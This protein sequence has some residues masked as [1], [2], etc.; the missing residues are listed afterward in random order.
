MQQYLPLI[1]SIYRIFCF[2]IKLHLLLFRL[3]RLAGDQMSRGNPGIADLSDH[4]RPTKLGEK[5]SS[6]YT[7]EWMDAYEELRHDAQRN[8]PRTIEKQLLDIISVS[9]IYN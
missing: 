6:L 1:T 9:I 5:W 4:N 7:E 8:Q 3:N 2:K